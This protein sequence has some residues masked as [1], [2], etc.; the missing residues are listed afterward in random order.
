MS[1]N[2]EVK[3][4]LKTFIYGLGILVELDR[5]DEEGKGYMRLKHLNHYSESDHTCILY[6]ERDIFHNLAIIS[7][8]LQE[9]GERKKTNEIKKAL[10]IKHE[11]TI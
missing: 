6:K 9:V 3:F 7:S 4:D 8:Y 11:N 10:G 2:P 1:K 5:W